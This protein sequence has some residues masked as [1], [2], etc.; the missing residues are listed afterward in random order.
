MHSKL[1]PAQRL[2]VTDMPPSDVAVEGRINAGASSFAFPSPKVRHVVT[3]RSTTW[4]SAR[5]RGAGYCLAAHRLSSP[6]QPGIRLLH[7]PL[8]APS[9]AFLAVCLPRRRRYG[10]TMFRVWDTRGLGSAFLPTIISVRVS[11]SGKGV[12]DRVPFWLK[13][14]SAFGLFLITTFISSLLMLTMP[15]SLAPYPP[16]RWQKA[17]SPHRVDAALASRLHCPGGFTPSR[18]QLRMR[19]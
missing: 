19:R 10:L 11:P 12:T 13:P 2:D 14:D 16:R 4:K 17:S 7:D 8:P 1:R 6:L 15:R 5:F 9:T 18:Y 3:S